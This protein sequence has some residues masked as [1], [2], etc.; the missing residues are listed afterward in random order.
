MSKTH[1]YALTLPS[2]ILWERDVPRERDRVREERVFARSIL[3]IAVPKTAI[4]EP[5]DRLEAHRRREKRIHGT[6]GEG[7]TRGEDL[8]AK[9]NK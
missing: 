8:R 3:K 5:H 2:P 6:A 7:R 4:R 9:I 1:F